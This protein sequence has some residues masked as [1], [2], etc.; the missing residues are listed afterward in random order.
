MSSCGGEGCNR[1]NCIG[2]ID[3]DI[4][5]PEYVELY[6]NENDDRTSFCRDCWLPQDD[7][8]IA[9]VVSLVGSCMRF[10]RY[11]VKN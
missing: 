1:I 10:V 7:D 5:S 3:A 4:E 8:D 11:D 2:C 9:V 6:W